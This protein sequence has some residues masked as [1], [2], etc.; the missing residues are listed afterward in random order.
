MESLCGS[1]DGLLEAIL[2][3]PLS[4]LPAQVGNET[5]SHQNK[6]WG[7]LLLSIKMGFCFAFVSVQNL[8]VL[9]V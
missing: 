2:T 8:Y 4:L 6:R 3:C 7:S 5:L 1:W 9:L